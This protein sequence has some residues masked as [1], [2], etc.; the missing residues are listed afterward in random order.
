[1]NRIDEILIFKHLQ[2]DEIKIIIDILLRETRERLEQQNKELV[3]P[4]NVIGFI[5]KNG[6]SKEYGARNIARYIKGNIL[7]KIAR[8]SLEKGWNDA[9]IKGNGRK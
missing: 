8:V 1:M 7:E 3:I 5:I 4:D 6:Y 9:N 2:E